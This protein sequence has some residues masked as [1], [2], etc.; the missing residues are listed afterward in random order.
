MAKPEMTIKRIGLAA[1]AGLLCGV[2]ASCGVS[3]G[4]PPAATSQ[5]DDVVSLKQ[6]VA[7][8]GTRI[9]LLETKVA[10]PQQGP[11]TMVVTGLPTSPLPTATIVPAVAGLIAD[12]NTKGLASA[13]VTIIEYVDFL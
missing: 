13:K 4:G 11:P 12:G 2:L 7:A 5:S 1:V 6:Q 8:Q 10:L 9:A 3:P